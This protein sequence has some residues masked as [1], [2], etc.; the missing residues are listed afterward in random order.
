[1]DIE[2]IRSHTR[3][4]IYEINQQREAIRIVLLGFYNTY[5]GLKNNL[6]NIS[7]EEIFE[8]AKPLLKK[9]KEEIEI[10][11]E[12]NEEITEYFFEDL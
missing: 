8:V 4:A 10:G 3:D 2:I 5:S 11:G 1:M 7:L 9:Q 12:E 6:S